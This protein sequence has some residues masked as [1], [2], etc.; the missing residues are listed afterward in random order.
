MVERCDL[1]DSNLA[2]AWPMDSRTDDSIGTLAD[3]I[4]DLVL[5]TFWLRVST[6]NVFKN[7]RG[8]P[9][10]KRTFLGAGAAG[11]GAGAGAVFVFG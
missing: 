5:C 4:E 7:N 3:N 9:T 10:L 2:P 1:L 8:I 11:A 6:R